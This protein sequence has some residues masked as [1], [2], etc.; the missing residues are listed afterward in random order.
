MQVKL[1]KVHLQ[2]HSV[3]MLATLV[4]ALM[5]SQLEIKRVQLAKD[6]MPLQLVPK[7]VL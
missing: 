4:K 1:D 3:S 5:Q 6:N 2:L 7:L